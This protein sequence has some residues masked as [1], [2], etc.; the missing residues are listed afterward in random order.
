[1][2]AF[3]HLCWKCWEIKRFSYQTNKEVF[4]RETLWVSLARLF[5][6]LC[7]D[8][9]LCGISHE[10][11]IRT[12]GLSVGPS[13]SMVRQAGGILQPLEAVCKICI[14]LCAMFSPGTGKIIFFI[15]LKFYFFLI[16]KYEQ[17]WAV[18]PFASLCWEGLSFSCPS[19]SL[20]QISSSTCEWND[21][22][23][24]IFTENQEGSWR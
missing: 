14:C 20:G 22:N 9:I 6:Y 24:Q 1:M 4:P 2:A 13:V 5:F 16:N 21:Q 18:L 23:I 7:P 3:S 15:Y 10:E 11:A 17:N 12:E 8:I 19:A